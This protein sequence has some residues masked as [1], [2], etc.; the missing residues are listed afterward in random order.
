MARAYPWLFTVV[1]VGV[2]LVQPCNA[3][4][5]ADAKAVLGEVRKCW[6]PPLGAAEENLK[7][8]ISIELDAVGRVVGEPAIV[9]VSAGKLATVFARST[10]RAVKMCQPYRR[11]LSHPLSG[12]FQLTF[13]AAP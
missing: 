7:A 8:D 10:I 9:Q 1:M 6:N 2:G 11:D 3:A 12:Q 4:E 5:S 13:V